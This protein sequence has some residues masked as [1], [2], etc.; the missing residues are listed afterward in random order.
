MKADAS[1]VLFVFVMTQP[2]PG[3][4]LAS[5]SVPW[6]SRLQC[7]YVFVS[8]ESTSGGRE[9][10]NNYQNDRTNNVDLTVPYD[11]SAYGA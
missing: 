5:M 1:T 8:S 11:N 7:P 10:H 4:N 9:T 2:T 3:T 6:R